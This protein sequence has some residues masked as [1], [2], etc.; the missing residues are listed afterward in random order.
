MARVVRAVRDC[1]NRLIAT[2]HCPKQDTRIRL[3]GAVL[4][5]LWRARKPK[6]RQTV[7][8]TWNTGRAGNANNASGA[9]KNNCHLPLSS[10]V[11]QTMSTSR[12]IPTHKKP[13]SFSPCVTIP[14]QICSHGQVFGSVTSWRTEGQD[15]MLLLLDDT[16]I[17]GFRATCNCLV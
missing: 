4:W 7:Q 12:V 11:S 13:S 9:K 6:R 10:D 8:N 5:H 3:E 15:Q 2:S 14:T 16:I 17:H 1:G